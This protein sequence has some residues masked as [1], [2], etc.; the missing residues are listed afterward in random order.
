MSVKESCVHRRVGLRGSRG[1]QGVKQ[2][3]SSTGPCGR[4]FAEVLKVSRGCLG[5]VSACSSEGEGGRPPR[6]APSFCQRRAAPVASIDLSFV[7]ALSEPWSS[8]RRKRRRLAMRPRRPGG[9]SSSACA[10]GA[11]AAGLGHRAGGTLA[12]VVKDVAR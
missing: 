8:E 7:P 11:A 9:A 5:K 3:C 6:N 10:S 1:S 4:V 12:G 2:S